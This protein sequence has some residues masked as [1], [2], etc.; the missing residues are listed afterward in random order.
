M[1][2]IRDQIFSRASSL[3]FFKKKNKTKKCLV[4]TLQSTDGRE[5]CSGVGRLT[6]ARGYQ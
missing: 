3:L 1:R 4:S 2:W 6:F 5:G